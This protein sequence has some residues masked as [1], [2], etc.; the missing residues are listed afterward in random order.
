MLN[1]K[2]CAKTIAEAYLKAASLD[3]NGK[4]NGKAPEGDYPA[5][6]A[7]AY[8]DYVKKGLVPGAI[9]T[10]GDA[11]ILETFM[12]GVSGSPG[13]VD[14]FAISLAEFWATVAIAPGIPAHGGTA[15]VS[16]TN[17]ASTKTADFKAA[18][19][20]S[21]TATESTPYFGVFIANLEAVVKT[22]SWTVTEMMPTVPPAP[23]PWPE[24]IA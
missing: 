6:F 16:V 11:I 10:G 2:D 8:N 12:R 3:V 17:D 20:A 21:Q 19:M 24:V 23:V 15:V 9:N 18:I 5:E 4:P 1:A 7:S 13:T 14:A 22:I